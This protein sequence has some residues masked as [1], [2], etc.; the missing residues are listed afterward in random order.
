M[1]TLIDHPTVVPPYSQAFPNIKTLYTLTLTI[2]F[3]F[4][5]CALK[6]KAGKLVYAF[7][8]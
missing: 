2:W 4:C 5:T 1:S 8:N 6:L 3:E 7:K